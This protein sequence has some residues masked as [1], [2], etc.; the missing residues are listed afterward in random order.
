MFGRF[1]DRGIV[2]LLREKK[3][4]GFGMLDIAKYIVSKHQ[5]LSYMWRVGLEVPFEWFDE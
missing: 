2:E 1:F 3:E 5:L 4:I